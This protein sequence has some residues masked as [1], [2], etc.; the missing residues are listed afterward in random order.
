MFFERHVGNTGRI[1]NH[2]KRDAGD[3]I[4]TDTKDPS[5]EDLAHDE[6]KLK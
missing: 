2:P 1:S 5:L 4:N 6:A 3:E